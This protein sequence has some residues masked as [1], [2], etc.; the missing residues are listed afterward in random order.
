MKTVDFNLKKQLYARHTFISA[1][2]VC[3]RGVSHELVRHRCAAAQEST[4]YVANSSATPLC[5][6]HLVTDDQ[7]IEAYAD[8]FS[9]KAIS[10]N[11]QLTEWEVRKVLLANGIQPR[12]VGN[13]GKRNDNYFDVIDCPEKAYLLGMIQTDGSIDPSG[14]FSITQHQDYM[15]YIECMMHEFSDYI[16]K[17]PDNSCYQVMIG[18]RHMVDRLISYGIVP[19]KSHNQS[20]A[21]VET[22][23]N[24]VPFEYKGDFIRG[25]IDGDGS[26]KYE[27]QP[28]GI[29]MS[30]RITLYSNN[31]RL[32]ELV[33]QH[34]HEKTGYKCPLYDRSEDTGYELG[35]YDRTKSLEIGQYLFDHFKYPFGHPK[36][37]SNWISQL[38]DT[39][40]VADYGDSKFQCIVP[41]MWSEW[42]PMSKFLF[43]EAM[44]MT[45]QTYRSLRIAGRK[46]QEA[47]AVLP[48]AL[49]TEVVLT[50]S[51]ERWDHFLNLRSRGLTGAPHPD[52][53]VLADKLLELIDEYDVTHS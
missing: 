38:T 21:D 5:E 19:N 28:K 39:F 53:K 12:Q 13:K 37:A 2:F 22:L 1:H 4:R 44:Y 18:S 40:Q 24:T 6:R 10:N 26:V 51:R 14:T 48:N 25:L 15:W 35:I 30:P 47:R 17:Y 3:D 34:I 20:A 46:P 9:M 45:E 8:G 31:R 7:I 43:C 27:V 16:C 33:Q 49:K 11:C 42:D 36:K 41:S 50:M 32:L 29:I 52:M 23:W